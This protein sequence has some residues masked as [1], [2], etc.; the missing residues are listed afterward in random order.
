MSKFKKHEASALAKVASEKADRVEQERRRKE[1]IEKKK[2]EDQVE[3]EKLDNDSKIVELT[4]EQAAKLQEEIDS[5]VRYGT[6]VSSRYWF[7]ICNV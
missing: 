4:D 3:E 6:L 1:R 5:K 2:K 7:L